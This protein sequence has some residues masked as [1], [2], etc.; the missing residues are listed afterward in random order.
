M[1][2]L[3]ERLRVTVDASHA[4]ERGL[5]GKQVLLHAQ[6]H[7]AAH[8]QVGQA[9]EIERAPDGAFSGVL[10]RHHRVVALAALHRAEYFVDR[11]Q[12]RGVDEQTEMPGD[13]GVAER[14]GRPQIRDLELLLQRQACRHDLPEDA[15]HGG[16][17]QRPRI[18]GRK[19]GEDLGL[20]FRPVGARPFLQRA[21]RLRV[22]RARIEVGQDLAVE[23]VDRGA[24]GGEV[25]RPLRQVRPWTCRGA[26]FLDAF[27]V[28][29]RDALQPRELLTVVQV[30]QR[31][32]L[33]RPAH[34]PNRL[35]AGADQHAACG[36]EH[37]FIVR[38]APAPRR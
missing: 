4:G 3:R 26:L 14:A 31:H 5:V 37:H 15:G 28:R 34:F 9:H 27:V 1:H 35:H 11:R 10:D 19:R 21:D 36:N 2:A 38:T 30:D 6:L 13:G 12:R 18:A 8:R 7:F 25:G 20:A 23:R 22:P 24:V 33:R 17:R 32:T 29:L 16:V